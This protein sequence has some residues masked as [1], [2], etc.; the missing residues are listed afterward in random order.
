MRSKRIIKSGLTAIIALLAGATI[1]NIIWY[2][3]LQNPVLLREFEIYWRDIGAN[4]FLEF[5]MFNYIPIFFLSLIL[6][7]IYFIDIKNIRKDA[8]E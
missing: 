3:R 6:L 5:N 1:Q 8:L 2:Q 4:L 7:I